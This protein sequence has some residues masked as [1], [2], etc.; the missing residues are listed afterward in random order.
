VRYEVSQIDGPERALV[1]IDDATGVMAVIEGPRGL[2][3]GVT[4]SLANG[5][6]RNRSYHVEDPDRPEADITATTLERLTPG[7]LGYR[8]KC[9][10]ILRLFGYQIHWETATPSLAKKPTRQGRASVSSPA[11]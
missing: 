1:D 9:D 11:S 3:S 10:G 5:A 2:R 8:F 6:W 7:T 4:A